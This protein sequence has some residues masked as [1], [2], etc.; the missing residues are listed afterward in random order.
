VQ[1]PVE[2]SDPRLPDT[3][4][5]SWWRNDYPVPGDARTESVFWG[6]FTLADDNGTWSGPFQGT[7]P[8][9]GSYDLQAILD[10][11]GANEGLMAILNGDWTG[12]SGWDI[13]G[14]IFEGEPPLLTQ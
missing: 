5:V 13:D 1:W 6:T 4:H 10:G 9:D 12:F 11:E 8:L 14:L 7:H 3:L 2:W